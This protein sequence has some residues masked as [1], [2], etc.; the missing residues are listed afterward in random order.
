MI[1]NRDSL[2]HAIIPSLQTLDS[3]FRSTTKHGGELLLDAL[4]LHLFVMPGVDD[5]VTFLGSILL[6]DV[7]VLAIRRRARIA[8]NA[9]I[10]AEGW[11]CQ[12]VVVVVILKGSIGLVSC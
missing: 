9:S 2:V 11:A 10:V 12:L 1:P 3:P 5:V 7:S 6:I 8:V 4:P